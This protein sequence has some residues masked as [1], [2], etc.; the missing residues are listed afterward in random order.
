MWRFLKNTI[1]R[2]YL[3]CLVKLERV[4]Y[5][6]RCMIMSTILYKLNESKFFLRK[7]RES[8]SGKESVFIYYLNAF[9]S[10]ARSITF[11]MQKE[12][13]T[14]PDFKKWYERYKKSMP[15]KF[16]KFKDLRN[17]SVKQKQIR[18]HQFIQTV[19]LGENG[20]ATESGESVEITIKANSNDA[21]VEHFS[22]NNKVKT[23]KIV[24]TSHDF[25]VE[26]FDT[27]KNREVRIDH[28]LKEADE[29]LYF[30]EKMIKDCINKFKKGE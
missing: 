6:Q 20:I 26:E 18:P 23:S 4:K 19:T 21:I 10:S 14:L 15:G 28:F 11:L 24:Q 8:F 27:K 12:Y 16:E 13:K 9:V 30:L 29:Y 17:I 7:T 5:Q 2:N 3:N 25:I 1:E 22:K